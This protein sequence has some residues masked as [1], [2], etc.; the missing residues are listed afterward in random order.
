MARQYFGSSLYFLSYSDTHISLLEIQKF[1]S[2]FFFVVIELR[3]KEPDF[4][5]SFETIM[6]QGSIRISTF[7]R[8]LALSMRKIVVVETQYFSRQLFMV[9]KRCSISSNQFSAD[10]HH[11]PHQGLV[12]PS[13][14]LSQGRYDYHPNTLKAL[15][16]SI[17]N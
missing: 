10:L 6:F 12:L 1:S 13:Y 16:S 15:C 17:L 7:H 4:E 11:L 9:H 8:D 2:S 3:R 14:V 5:I